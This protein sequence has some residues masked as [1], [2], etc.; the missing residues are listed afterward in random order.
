MS[1]TRCIRTATDL[2]ACVRE[3]APERVA[4]MLQFLRGNTL[5][6]EDQADYATSLILL[7][8]SPSGPVRADLNVSPE[9]AQLPLLRRTGQ[10][11]PWMHGPP[12]GFNS[13]TVTDV[14][15]Q[16]TRSLFVTARA[17]V[18]EVIDLLR[19]VLQ[20]WVADPET[21][22]PEWRDVAAALPTGKD[23]EGYEVAFAHLFAALRTVR[24]AG[25]DV[26]VDELVTFCHRAFSRVNFPLALPAELVAC[27][28]AAV[29]DLDRGRPPAVPP[30]DLLRALLLALRR[31]SFDARHLGPA[32][33]ERVTGL[34][35]KNLVVQGA[36]DLSMNEWNVAF[37]RGGKGPEVFLPESEPYPTRAYNCLI[38][39][40]DDPRVAELV[41]PVGGRQP[42]IGATIGRQ[43]SIAPLR[44]SPGEPFVRL[45]HSD[46]ADRRLADLI[47]FAVYG[48]QILRG[49]EVVKRTDVVDEFQDLRHVF[50]LPDIN[51]ESLRP[52]AEQPAA[53]PH[54]AWAFYAR[55]RTELAPLLPRPRHLFNL[56]QNTSVWL[57][58][59]ELLRDRNLRHL[60][61]TL[62]DDKRPSM[63]AVELVHLGGPKN[64]IEFCLRL[65]GYRHR[66][67]TS[68]VKAAGDFTWD[69]SDETRPRLCIRLKWNNY[70]CTLVGIGSASGADRPD[71]VYALA[72][73]HVYDR[74]QQTIW[75][76]AEVLRAVGATDALVMDEGQ[77]VF[78]AYLPDHD[79]AEEF[80]AAEQ[81][82]DS[83]ETWTPVPLA[84]GHSKSL[85]M[86]V[87]KR[88]SLRATLAF[89]QGE[90]APPKS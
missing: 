40:R 38:Q 50:S 30:A 4:G 80:R 11:T 23:A 72:W 84:F 42:L 62:E 59:Y 44:F 36:G 89:W 33:L 26:A 16:R 69:E 6:Q 53:D 65:K 49:G 79:A 21:T 58:E 86:R 63:I 45:A 1:D 74:G 19:L 27:C 22:V 70:P 3:T 18:E 67:R 81:K 73:G 88:R 66:D 41:A 61:C 51:P 34:R 48:K 76:C 28:R 39:W 20:V 14:I 2:L 24:A 83:I 68:D 85:N 52:P 25:P 64:W 5:F 35:R 60:A 15:L 37:F 7:T 12:L 75:D 54:P 46:R 87:L 8:D 82:G 43:L 10:F 57:L 13:P 55:H 47:D 90:A 32:R 9:L 71:T 17:A 29:R 56:H 78:Q 77:D 31:T